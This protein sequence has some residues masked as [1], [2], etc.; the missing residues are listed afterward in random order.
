MGCMASGRVAAIA[1]RARSHRVWPLVGAGSAR[2][3]VGPVLQM[4]QE[5]GT[6]FGALPAFIC[7]SKGVH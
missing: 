6:V 7:S 5:A 3:G 2:D 4:P 1:G